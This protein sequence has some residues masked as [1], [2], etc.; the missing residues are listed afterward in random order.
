MVNS[1]KN[2]ISFFF[3]KVNDHENYNLNSKKT[4]EKCS[5]FYLPRCDNPV[6][7]ESERKKTK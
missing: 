6:R 5:K 1:R 4:T 3:Q 2:L 7:S